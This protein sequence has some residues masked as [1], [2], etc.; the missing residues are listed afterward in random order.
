[1]AGIAGHL[2]ARIGLH[3]DA[4][5]ILGAD[6]LQPGR[7]GAQTQINR[8]R[9]FDRRRHLPGRAGHGQHAHRVAKPGQHQRLAR[10]HQHQ[11]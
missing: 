9:P 1:M 4:Q 7:G 5:P 10:R 6:I 2:P 3:Q 8:H 11:R